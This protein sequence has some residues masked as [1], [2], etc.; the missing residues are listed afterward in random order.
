MIKLRHMRA[1]FCLLA[2]ALLA[3]VALA[4]SPTD[5]AVFKVAPVKCTIRFGVKAGVPI[6]GVFTNGIPR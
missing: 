4:Q 5:V 3:S 6:E 2:F 1:I